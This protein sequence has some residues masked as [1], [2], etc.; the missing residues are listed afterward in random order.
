[1]A[2]ETVRV[3]PARLPPTI[4]TTPN[5]P[6][7]C[8]KLSTSAVTTPGT[9]IGKI[10]RQNVR[11]ASARNT[12]EAP[13]SFRSTLSTAATSGCTV[14]GRLYSTDASTSPG[15]VNANP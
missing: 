3:T 14:N 13:S 9:D 2:I 10:T 6:N 12:A 11:S 15:N 5:S 8:A 1:M 4:S 7:V